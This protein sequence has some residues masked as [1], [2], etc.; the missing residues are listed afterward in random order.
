[1]WKVKGSIRFFLSILATAFV[2]AGV[3]IYAQKILS[4]SFFAKDG[5]IW[6]NF[7]LQIFFLAPYVLMVFFAGFFT[8]KFSKNKVM[9]WSSLMMT[10]FVIAQSVLVTVDY[11]RIAFWLSIGLSCGFAIHSAAKYAIIKEMFGVRNL[12]YANAFLQIFSISGIIAASWLAIVGVNLINLDQLVSYEAVRRITEKSVVIPWI[13]T[14]VSVLGTVANFM[15]PRVKF[16]DLNVSIDKVKRHLSLGFRVPTLRASI[17]ALSMF[18]ALAQVFVL[19]YQDVSGSSTVNMMQDYMSFAIVGLMVGTIV[20]AHFS[21][22][23]IESGFVPLGMFGA[24]ICMFLVP[25]LVHPVALVLL[26]SLTGFFGGLILV[27]VNALLQ[28][29]TRP[30]NSGSVIA[31]A[32]LIQAVVLVAFLFVFTMMV[33]NTDVRPQNYFIGLAVISVGVF[34]WSIS[35]LPQAMLRTLLRFVFSRYRIRVLNVQNIPNEG[36][37]LL[38]GNHHSFIDWAMVQMASPRPL[39]IASNKDHFDK[40]YLRAVLKRLGMIRID[41]RN[42]KV[43]MDKIHAAL[44]AG[45]AVVIFPSGEVSKSPHVEPF[46]IDYSSAVDGTKA[47]VIPFYIQGLWGS[48]YSYSSSNM[49]GASAERSVTVA[50]G[51][52]LPANTPPNE[53]RAVIRR[54]S[55]DAWNYAVS[56]VHPIADSWIRTYKKYVK[57]GPAIY[58]PD[59]AHFSGY[60]LMGAVMAFRGYLKK[61]LGKNEQNVGIMLPPSPAGVIV[62]L[63]LWVIGKT[64]VNLNYTS[65]VENVKFC[66]DRAECSTVITS[67]QFVQKLKGRGNDYSQIAS[68]KVRLLYAEDIM[69]EIPKVKIAAFLVLCMIMPSWLIRLVFVKRRA[70]DDNAVIVFSSGSEGTPKGVELTQRNLMGNIQQLAC[71]LNV[72]RGDVM[73]S[74][75]PLFHSFGLTVTTL[76]N[77]TEGCPIVAV[78]DPTDVKTMSRVCAEFQVTFL[79]AT[80]TFL[81]AFTVSRYVHPLM[82]KSVR[83][84]IAGA[85]ALRPELAT[86]FRLKFGKEIYEGYGCTET[87]PVASVNTENTLFDDYTTLQ[88]N[89]KPG[90]VGP[91]LPGTQ[92]LIV[93]PETNEELPTGEAGMILIGGC[94]VM[95]GYLKDEDRTKSVIVQKDGIRYYRTGDKGYL[96]EDGFLT[97]VD[98]YSRFAKLGGEMISLGAVE[99]KIQDTPVLQGCDYV[100]TAIPDATKGEKIVLL[101]QGEKDPKDVLSELRASGMPPLMLPSAAF[102]VDVMPKLGSGKADFVTAKKMAKELVEKK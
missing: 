36:P 38:V 89:N 22:D 27:P 67:R 5:I 43:A 26:Y 30:N 7:M 84:I 4:G 58:S 52:A 21:K 100:V 48:N 62:N 28:Y 68:D 24:S 59:G 23:F 37:I 46:T 32:N 51:E 49:F 76:L 87:A 70:M 54:I 63:A 50:F 92:F 61:T 94:Q 8:N 77:L 42:P 57:N 45:K 29:N 99:K 2:Q 64:N 31:L 95:K 93:D 88:V 6:Q 56:F 98:R 20:A 75:L 97:I 83:I 81:R 10:L 40:W 101:Y 39:C 73:L 55:I 25:F 3:F 11:P 90:T 53:I 86:A 35:N 78:A 85:E 44:L 15:I 18:W 14:A 9:A 102:N 12:S 19:T 71:I 17:I 82:F 41:N 79:V 69:K 72:S 34:V 47:Q 65:S 80:P 96:D 91:A 74:E 33:R 66:C 60:K 13:L 16:E 1:M